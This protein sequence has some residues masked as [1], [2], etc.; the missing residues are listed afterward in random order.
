MVLVFRNSQIN[1]LEDLQKLLSKDLRDLLK[2]KGENCGGNK[3]DLVLKAYA[4][5]MRD[6][7][8]SGDIRGGN[9]LSDFTPDPGAFS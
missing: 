7:S 4:L 3:A 9:D 2:S 6:V 1:S 8:C 5:L